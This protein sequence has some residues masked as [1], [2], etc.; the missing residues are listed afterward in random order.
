MVPLGNMFTMK[1]LFPAFGG[2][3]LAWTVVVCG[4]GRSLRRLFAD[5]ASNVL[6]RSQ[7][8]NPHTS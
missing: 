6:F 8:S 3:G 2:F 7:P 4:V 5:E 1:Q